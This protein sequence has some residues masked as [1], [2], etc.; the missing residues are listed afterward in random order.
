MPYDWVDHTAELE[1]HITAPTEEAVFADALTALADL[2]RDGRGRRG[3]SFDVS[4][5]AADRAT[6]LAAWLDEL[7]FRAESEGLVPDAVE[8]LEVGGGRLEARVRAH[9]GE[10]RHVVQ[11]VGYDRLAFEEAGDGFRACLVL[12]V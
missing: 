4:L 8:A 5:S 3:E 10:P 11:G 9:R 1:L 12:D 7:V 2:V 6:L